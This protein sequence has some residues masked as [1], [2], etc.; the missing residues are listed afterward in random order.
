[1]LILTAVD[2]TLGH[3]HG[4]SRLGLPNDAPTRGDCPYFLI[5]RTLEES[6]TV[7]YL[8]A[9]YVEQGFQPCPALL[10]KQQRGWLKI[11]SPNNEAVR[12]ADTKEC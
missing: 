10:G 4:A 12:R 11:R 5:L 8:A 2:L 7:F 3:E 6:V 9:S 1:M